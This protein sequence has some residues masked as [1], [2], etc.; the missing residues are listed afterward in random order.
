MY[1]KHTLVRASRGNKTANGVASTS[2]VL[3]V[4]AN[5][6]LPAAR[7]KHNIKPVKEKKKGCRVCRIKMFVKTLHVMLTTVDH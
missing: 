6:N 5:G 7:R 4:A 2:D 1:V 3:S